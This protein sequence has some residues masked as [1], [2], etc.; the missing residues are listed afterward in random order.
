MNTQEF[1]LAEV[2]SSTGPVNKTEIQVVDAPAAMH[3][4]PEPIGAVWTLLLPL[5]LIVGLYILF[6]RPQYKKEKALRESQKNL[7]KGD[8]VVTRGGIWGTVVGVKE[9]EGIVVIK[10]ADDVK[11]EVS[12]NAIEA[13]NPQIKK[14]E[15]K[16]K[17]A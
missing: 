15:K 9:Q 1:I 14:E 5:L 13:I 8:R 11:I 10:I 2:T 7:S 4:K 6:M 16:G 17:K 12:S 3:N